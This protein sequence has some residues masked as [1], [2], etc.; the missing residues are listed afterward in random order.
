MISAELAEIAGA[1]GAG[2]DLGR[3]A[4]IGALVV[5]GAY[6]AGH[7]AFRRGSAAICALLMVLAAAA[8]QLGWLGFFSDVSPKLAVL[9]QGVFGAAAVIFLSSI[10]RVVRRN[11][12]VGGLM[13]AAALTLVGIGVINLTGRA[14]V[15]GLMRVGLFFVGALTIAFSVFQWNADPAARLIAPGAFFAM[16]APFA[17]HL[18]P[19]LGEGFVLLPS[20]LFAIGVVAASIVA[21]TQDGPSSVAELG[22]HVHGHD[23]HTMSAP[24]PREC[25]ADENEHHR[26]SETQLAK[27][28]DYAGVAVW[29]WCP[30]GAHQTDGMPAVMGADS[31]APFTPDAVKAFIHKEDLAKLESKVLS[32]ALG[33]GSFDVALKLHDG[34]LVRFRGARAVDNFGALERLVAFIENVP[35]ASKLAKST[36]AGAPAAPTFAA[37]GARSGAPLQHNNVLAAAFPEALAKGDISAVFQPIVALDNGKVAGFE[38]L[39]RWPGRPGEPDR[40]GPE[41]MVRAAHAAGKGGALARVVLEEAAQH[42]AKE[43]KVQGRRDLF[44]A[45][46]LSFAQMREH[47]FPAALKRVMSQY[48][49]PPKSVVL[50]LTESEAIVDKGAA[51]TFRSLKDAGAALAFDDFGSG[52]SSLNNLR[53]YAFDYLKI[54]KSYVD[55]LARGDDSGKIAQAIA[56]LGKELGLVVIAEGVETRE[57]ADAARRIGCKLGQGYAFGA[58]GRAGPEPAFAADARERAPR[59]SMWR[60][61]LR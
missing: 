5:S 52:F 30:H 46:N 49:L 19:L 11:A 14:E 21:L 37:H 58:P 7:A 13:L 16:A 12:L 55:G 8:V 9:V 45:L 24:H 28:A 27:V 36:L 10:F 3:G 31:R 1:T 48:G 35:D 42:L 17:V 23:D 39:A 29:D 2:L 32:P 57:T 22:L 41:E 44:V 20:A 26:L 38:T 6:L 15:A 18:T 25:E 61:D 4:I 60:R 40:A 53:K 56:A 59:R 47:G 33:D 54:D 43:F 51:E 50:E 34:R